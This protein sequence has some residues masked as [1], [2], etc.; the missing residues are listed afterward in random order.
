MKSF[1]TLLAVLTFAA[2]LEA[3]R[4]SDQITVNVVEVPVYVTRPSGGPLEGLTKSDFELF[5][6]GKPQSID[7]FDVIDDREVAAAAPDAPRDLHRR[8]L[9]L[10][11]FDPQNSTMNAIDRAKSAA[12]K[13]VDS[14]PAGDTF[15]VAT[16]RRGGIE[17]LAAFTADRVA[18]KRAIDTL[19]ASAAGD[20]FGL[21]TLNTERT[22]WEPRLT[23][24]GDFLRTEAS[25]DDVDAPTDNVKLD[26]PAASSS[27]FFRNGSGYAAMQRHLLLQQK[28][29]G[30]QHA[31]LTEKWVAELGV[32]AERLALLDGV[33]HV[34]LMREGGVDEA[35]PRA[36]TKMHA[37]FRSAGV[38][39]D[40][41][42][43]GGVRAPWTTEGFSDGTTFLRSL[44][45]ETGGAVTMNFDQLRKM[46]QLTYVLGFHPPAN[47]KVWNTIDVRVR[48]QRFG[49]DVRHRSGYATGPRNATKSDGLLLADVL[50]NDIPQNGMTVDLDVVREGEGATLVARVPGVEVLALG[51]NGAT[52]LDVFFYVFDAQNVVAGWTQVRLKVDHENGRAFLSSRPYTIRQKFRLGPGKYSGKALLRVVDKDVIG[53]DRASFA[54]E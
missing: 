29:E 39:L 43:I 44:S 3:Q 53:F 50:V 2:S 47:G 41:V 33:K 30:E 40:A 51:E 7:Y 32:L 52:M 22:P 16:T 13:F 15:A 5:V 21:A 36:L 8:R 24:E 37:K 10:L 45:L 23:A 19:H 6:N 27:S 26:D 38:I 42:D 46:Q 14:A 18:V 25:N 35:L 1:V 12:E 28:V 49:T 4:A 9:F 20:A 31:N 54:V 17:F 48:N 34:V 11:L